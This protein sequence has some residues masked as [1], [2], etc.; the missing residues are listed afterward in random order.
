[1]KRL[2]CL[3]GITLV[4]AVSASSGAD[5]K[6]PFRV[7]KEGELPKD[8][9]LGKPIDLNGYF[10]FTPPASKQAW[11]SRRQDAREQVLVANGLWPLPP[12]TPLNPV[13][14]GKIDR[15]DYTVEKV[16]FASYPGHYVT[17]NLYR[18]KGKT[19]KLAGVLCPHGHWP[20]GRFYENNEKAAE[21]DIAAGAEKTKEG[22]RY[23]LQARCAM[24]ARMGC[25][26]FHYDMVGY[27]DS[28]PIGHRA[29]F[30]D[31]DAEL[32]LQSFMGLQTWNSI[33]SLDFLLSLP[34]VDPKRIG[35]TGASGGGTQTFLLCAVDDRP[36]AAFPAVMVS[37]AMQGGCVCE[38]CSYLRVGTGNIELAGL[39]APKPLFMAAANDWTKDI[40]TK[41]LPELKTLY[42]LLDAEDKVAAK[43][44]AFPHNYNQVSRE[45]M[46]GW[47]N[48]HLALGQPEPVVEKPFVPVPP[49]DLSVYDE[50]HPL[51]KDAANAEALRKYMKEASDKQIAALLPK[52][53]D[54]LKEYR[55]VIGTALR[56][57][58]HDRLPG[59]AEV[60][61][62]EIGVDTDK[63]G[64]RCRRLLLGRAGKD[65]QIPAVA[66]GGKSYNG[67]LVVW[68]HPEGKK[69]LWKDGQLTPAAKQVLDK[70]AII[71][72]P[73]L[74]LTGEFEGAKPQA[75]NGSYAGFTFGYNRSLLANRVHDILTVVGYA[76]THKDVKTVH[77]V[78]WEKAGP[79]ALLARA[80]CGDRVAR[81]A[82]DY[83]RFRFDSVRNT[84][85]EM[86]IPGALKYGGLSAFAGLCAPAE[87]YVHNHH[88]SGSG[89]WLK[90]AYEAAGQPKALTKVS[91]K[92]S[93]D[94]V[95]EWLLR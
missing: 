34:E 63:E 41:G 8:S 47:F 42:K 50:Q 60:E 35:V 95:I 12:K 14:H 33:R 3:V 74:F 1:M 36:T 55:R 66:V 39:F 21:K 83:D 54:S 77:L 71:L 57:M 45:W 24:L 15:D 62:K 2:L 79:W 17:G 92:A 49:K 25:V 78:G 94:K 48:K 11:D 64:F 9:R 52:D 16:F 37:T 73:D 89:E 18:P 31:A 59:K 85:D 87:L 32:N 90:P 91:E 69:S 84:T 82:L 76:V 22:A 68:V 46:Y 28:K 23:P 43:H 65:E 80:L 70:G 40:E 93:N 88:A 10:P 7:L 44:A 75:V 67:T 58:V 86:M 51:P 6:A 56:V 19:G 20:N 13:I 26:V 81:T 53:A 61:E 30:T 4:V 5:E 38:N 29:G 72:A 27:A